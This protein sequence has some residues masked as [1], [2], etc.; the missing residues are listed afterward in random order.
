MNKRQS[1]AFFLFFL[2][3]I[4]LGFYAGLWLARWLELPEKWQWVVGFLMIPV[5]GRLTGRATWTTVKKH[6]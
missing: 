4:T 3:L 2:I 6:F 1:I 5:V